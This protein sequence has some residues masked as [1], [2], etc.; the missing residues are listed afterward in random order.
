LMIY[1][2]T[3]STIFGALAFIAIS[4]EQDLLYYYT[5]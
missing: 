2:F 4:R 3:C 5:E 1:R